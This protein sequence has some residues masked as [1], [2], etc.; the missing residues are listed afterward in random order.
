MQWQCGVSGM[1]LLRSRH[2]LLYLQSFRGVESQP[3][4]EEFIHPEAEVVSEL[5]NRLH[6]GHLEKLSFPL[7]IQA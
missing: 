2:L 4:V 7:K 6:C 3:L 5:E 1:C